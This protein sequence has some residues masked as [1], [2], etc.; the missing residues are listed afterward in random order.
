MKLLRPDCG[1]VLLEAPLTANPNHRQ[2]FFG[3]SAAA[4]A[5]L[6][7]WALAHQ[8]FL[9]E[10]ELDVHLVIQRSRMEYL[11]PAA[12]EVEAKCLAPVPEQWDRMLRT[13]QRRGRGR[14]E[15]EVVLRA[16]GAVI[17]SFKGS[18]VVLTEK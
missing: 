11:E 15:L 9:E 2:T 8:K 13:V 14:I 18:F 10:E 16:E 3:G 4:P 1:G 5:T 17:G 7:A 12:A 6:A